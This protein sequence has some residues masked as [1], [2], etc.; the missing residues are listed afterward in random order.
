MY[1]RGLLPAAENRLKSGFAAERKNAVT[2]LTFNVTIDRFLLLKKAVMPLQ[3]RW[4]YQLMQIF[5]WRSESAAA[6]WSILHCERPSIPL[7]NS[8]N[9]WDSISVHRKE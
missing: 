6:K 4:Q 5:F 7:Q 8:R 3:V 1:Q 9:R 2:L